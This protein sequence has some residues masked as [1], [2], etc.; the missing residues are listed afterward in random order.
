MGEAA[1]PTGAPVQGTTW[2]PKHHNGVDPQNSERTGSSNIAFY[3]HQ[4][5]PHFMPIHAACHGGQVVCEAALAAQELGRMTAGGATPE[6]GELSP[7]STLSIT[8]TGCEADA[9]VRASSRSPSNEAGFTDGVK[10]TT[11]P[12]ALDQAL[13]PGSFS[14]VLAKHVGGYRCVHTCACTPARA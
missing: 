14:I 2:N 8:V 13:I 9:P 11:M 4:C 10:G 6:V 5:Q 12:A 1:G 7:F 3:H